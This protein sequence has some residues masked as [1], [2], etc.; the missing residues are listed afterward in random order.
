IN[1]RDVIRFQIERGDHGHVADVEAKLDELVA[2]LTTP[3][4]THYARRT[5]SGK[6]VEFNFKPLAGGERLGLYRDITELKER[7]DA[8]AS[9]RAEVESTRAVMQTVLDNM[10]DGVLLCG[11]P[12]PGG[13]DRPLLFYNKQILTLHRHGPGE[14]RPGM[15]FS[16]V[17]R[18]LAKRGE[19]GPIE[20][21]ETFIRERIAQLF[22]PAG[23]RYEPRLPDGRYVEFVYI[24]LADGTSFSV[25]RDTPELKDRAEVLA[26]AKETAESAR[27][28]VESTR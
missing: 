5:T 28:E 3:G 15:L 17:L 21:G 4:G 22:D 27:A 18:L 6:F 10:T 14:I 25:Q 12:V 2:R 20:D 26:T 9:A 13:A 8:L 1:V 19:Y 24:P 7:E 11:R 23:C 16:E